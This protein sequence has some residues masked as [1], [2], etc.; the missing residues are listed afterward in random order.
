MGEQIILDEKMI[1]QKIQSAF[2]EIDE[3]KNSAFDI[4]FHMTDWISDVNELVEVYSNIE[5]LKNDEITH[6]IYKFLAHV[7]NHINAAK[8][9][10]GMGKT[11]DIFNAGIFE[12]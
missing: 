10:S 9:L 12:D 3:T 11:E 5:K 2:E 1:Q 4:A 6:F 7:P 8:K